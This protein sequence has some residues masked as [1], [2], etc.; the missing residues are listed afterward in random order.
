[1]VKAKTQTHRA[2]LSMRVRAKH[3][4]VGISLD[5][6]E[7]KNTHQSASLSMR[8]KGKTQTHRASLSMRVRAETH[9]SGHLAR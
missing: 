3:T 7:G 6:G 8:V 1:M 4:P 5:E 9:T 2:S